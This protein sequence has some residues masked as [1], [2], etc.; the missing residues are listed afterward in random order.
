MC[1]CIRDITDKL[2]KQIIDKFSKPKKP[3]ES[4]YIATTLNGVAVVDIT[5]HL[6]N[7]LKTE[8]SYV[9]AEYCPWC[10]VKYGV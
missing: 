10:G 7:Q 5:I 8:R 6:E 9:V 3:V 4:F 2:Q 1:E